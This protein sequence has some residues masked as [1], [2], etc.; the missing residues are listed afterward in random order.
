MGRAAR[1]VVPQGKRTNSNIRF[2]RWSVVEPGYL[3]RGIAEGGKQN[4]PRLCGKH[5]AA[6]ARDLNQ[7]VA[8]S[9]VSVVPLRYS[10]THLAAG[11]STNPPNLVVEVLN[12]AAP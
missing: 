4:T 10:H 11:R 6:T 7:Q 2:P 9:W 3:W 8:K 5:E 12:P 1:L